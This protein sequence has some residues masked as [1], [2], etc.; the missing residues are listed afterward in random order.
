MQ[1]GRQTD[2]H[3][4]QQSNYCSLKCTVKFGLRETTVPSLVQE[5]LVAQSCLVLSM[6]MDA[7]GIIY[8][9]ALHLCSII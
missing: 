5:V 2:L 6:V 7:P 8:G 3:N 1:A 4:V 9:I